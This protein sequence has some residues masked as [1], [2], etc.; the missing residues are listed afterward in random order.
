MFSYIVH[1]FE[2]S[3]R[4]THIERIYYKYEY[5][6]SSENSCLHLSSFNHL[7]AYVRRESRTV[8]APFEYRKNEGLLIIFP[9]YSLSSTSNFSTFLIELI[10]AEKTD[11]L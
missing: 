4:F 9:S 10:H 2:L 3:S 8:K 1:C 7:K 6:R 5:E 11:K